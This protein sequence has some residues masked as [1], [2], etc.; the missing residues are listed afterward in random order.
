MEKL[1]ILAVDDNANNLV[2]LRALIESELNIEMI[3]CQSGIEALDILMNGMVDLL[4]LDLQMPDMDGFELTELIRS[5][6][7]TSHIPIIL[8]TA[9]FQT[10]AYKQR[11]FE[12][13][14]ED[15]ITKPIKDVTLLNRIKAYLRPIEKERELSR[16]LE[17]KVEERTR[18]LQ[19]SNLNLELEI[20]KRE[21]TEIRLRE[22]KLEAEKAT[23]A[24][25]DFLA[26]MS[27]EIRTPMNGIIG[28]T[29]LLLD[30]KLD[31]EQS[32]HAECIKFSADSLLSIINDILD[33]SKIESGHLVLESIP[34]NI[35]EN[36][37]G[38]ITLLKHL[39]NE[40]GIALD[41]VIDNNTP[42]FILSDQTR[43]RQILLNLTSNAIKFTEKGKVSIEINTTEIKGDTCKIQ[44][45]V[46]DTGIGI[47]ADKV[48][49]LFK[50][51]SQVDVSTTRKFGGTGLG[52]AISAKL[53]ELFGGRIRVESRE[54][55]GSFFVFEMTATIAKHQA[56]SDI[57]NR[58][59]EN[60]II[61][62]FKHNNIKILVADDHDINIK[63]AA[64]VFKKLGHVIDT[65]RDGQ[66]AVDACLENDYDLVFM[67]CAMPV[68]DGYEA[69]A[70]IKNQI[71]NNAPHIIAM[72][73]SAMQGDREKCIEKGM[74]DYISKPFAIEDLSDMITKYTKIRM[75]QMKEAS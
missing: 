16:E 45:G 39:A 60:E 15:Y 73:A 63:L 25:S 13:G 31:P 6:K 3:Q 4:I 27:H 46:R 19:A 66:E 11:G 57:K 72:T 52:L 40:K 23:E 9:A 43:L 51:F 17:R 75:A 70:I 58:I 14:V 37:N 35:S 29:N 64:M 2:T 5:R 67:D 8:L 54:G 74:D 65:A 59:D 20:K 50:S 44:I 32:E 1:R 69:T 12:L 53:V 34:V 48:H 62:Q 10:E 21:E 49:L 28:M 18:E 47:P 38:C 71:A 61:S 7:K 55:K 22:S 33:F 36:V 41:Y 56:N 68:M 42:E 24:K 26:K 30:T